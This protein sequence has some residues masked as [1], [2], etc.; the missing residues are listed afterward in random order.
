MSL[1]CHLFGDREENTQLN[2]DGF[3]NWKNLAAHLKQHESSAEHLTNMDTWRT[4]LQ[5]LQ[6]STAI[7]QVNQDVIAPEVNRWKEILTRLI[8][9][10]NHLLICVFHGHSYRLFESGNGNFLGQVELMAQFDPVT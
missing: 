10:V 5:K 9:I 4:L 2:R 8:A 6:T 1:C 7:D 3:K